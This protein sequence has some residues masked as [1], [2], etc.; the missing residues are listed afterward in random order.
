MM[1]MQMNRIHHG[2]AYRRKQQKSR[3]PSLLSFHKYSGAFRKTCSLVNSHTV[4][5]STEVY[6]NEL[7]EPLLDWADT[8]ADMSIKSSDRLMLSNT[9]GSRKQAP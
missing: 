3:P 2:D 9:L 1:I 5:N 6:E 7:A 4:E 8:K